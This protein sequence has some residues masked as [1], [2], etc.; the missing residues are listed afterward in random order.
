MR[1]LQQL[2]SCALVTTGRTGSDYLQSLLDSHPE[3]LTFNGSLPFYRDFWRHSACQAAPTCEA[4]DVVD[5]FIG[6]H[7]HKLKSKYDVVERKDQLGPSHDQSLSLDTQAF[8]AH[9]IGLLRGHELSGRNALLALYGAY[10]LCLGHAL[11]AKRV[12]FHHAHHLDELD[13]FLTH[14]PSASILLTTRDPRAN[15]VSGIENWRAFNRDTDNQEHVYRYIKRI[16]EDSTPCA[17]KH[18][19]YAAIRLEDLPK[20][21]VMEELRRWLGISDDPCLTVSTWGGLEWHGDALSKRHYDSRGFNPEQTR[22]RWESRLGRLDK[23]VLN[24]LMF[25]RLGHYGYPSRDIHWWDA[26][27]VPFLLP[28]PLKYERRFLTRT[29]IASKIRS[30]RMNEWYQVLSA[31]AYYVMRVCLFFK[32]WVMMVRGVPFNGPWLRGNGDKVGTA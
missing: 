27:V 7:I 17:A 21:S 9:A 10:N 18:R 11:S 32:Y 13:L 5:E 23:Y 20:P 2:P 1:R 15:F 6:H 24:Y 22:N 30:G 19:P 3:V 25:S 26:L 31:P 28:V 8:R 14:F 12:F 4:D 16:L 29:Y